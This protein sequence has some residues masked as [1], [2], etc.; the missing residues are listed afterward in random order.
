MRILI[1]GATGLIGSN[2]I[3]NLQPNEITVLTRNVSM[4]EQKLG[5]KVYFLSSL[6]GI[7]NLDKFDVVINLAGEP[8]VNKKWSPEQK[9][10]IQNSRWNITATLTDLIKNSENP[11][12]LFISGS[13]I[14]YYGRQGD[15]LIDEDFTHPHDEFSHQLCDR[16]EQLALEA[17]SAKTRVCVL[18]TGIVLTKRGGALSKMLLP[19][20]LGLGG[21]IGDGKQYMSW[22][23]L[24][25]MLNAIKH[26][27]ENTECQGIYNF[28][29]PNPVT[30]AVFSHALASSLNRPDFL[31]MPV[32]VMRIL[33]G[34]MADLVLY[35]QRVIPKRLLESGFT[36]KHDDIKEAFESLKL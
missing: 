21:P 10:I 17:K 27:I 6:Q 9:Q 36:F 23:H 24:E 4:A 20:K 19:F 22:I 33:M 7:T 8:I 35:G 18:R 1:T 3:S 31:R 16:W 11:P 14:G 32:S 29:A 15:E 13:A 26:L 30:N 34:E 5:S 28:T 2:L 25:D 12:G